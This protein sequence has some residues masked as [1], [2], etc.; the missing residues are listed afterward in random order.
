LLL[1]L[2]GSAACGASEG[3]LLSRTR[4]HDA[5]SASIAGQAGASTPAREAPVQVGMSLQYQIVGSIDTSVD[6][7]LFVIDLFDA[8]LAKIAELHAKGRVVIGYVSVGSLED[9]RKD[10]ASFPQAAVGKQLA[11]YPNESWLDIR[12][13]AVRSAMGARLDLA[14][15]NGFDGIFAS[16]LG[17]Y[18]TNSGFPL[19]RADELDY[20]RFVANA[21]QSR[22]L[23]AGLSSDFELSELA[24][25][26][27]WALAEGCIA[28]GFCD[29]LKPFMLQA[30]P[31]F[32]IETEGD[33]AT[34]CMKAAGY[35][36]P[37]TLKH[38]SSDTWRMPCM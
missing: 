29:Q 21:A 20:A 12:S 30:K 36:I 10:V 3:A 34:V 22:G 37:T 33:Q 6:A 5:G 4:K 15:K 2:F 26:Y 14:R 28:H 19:T 31:V 7:Q 13:A 18:M 8:P 9:W 17:G 32:N 24:T 11:N 1:T 16:T 38:S 25:S 27:D 35:G 23:S